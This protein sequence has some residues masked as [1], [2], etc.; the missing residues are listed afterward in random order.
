MIFRRFYVNF[1]LETEEKGRFNPSK[2]AYVHMY[3]H[4]HNIQIVFT[5]FSIFWKFLFYVYSVFIYICVY[6]PLVFLVPLEATR[7]HWIPW[8]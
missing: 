5:L 7:E 6:A 4:K 8:N 3:I 1:V 2:R